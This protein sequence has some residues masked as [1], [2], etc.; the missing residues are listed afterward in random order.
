V[1]IGV[2]KSSASLI[3]A[4]APAALIG[5]W[6]LGVLLAEHPPAAASSWQLAAI[7]WLG[8]HDG[9]PS[10]PMALAYGCV[11]FGPLLVASLAASRFWAELFSRLRARPLDDGWALWAWLYALLLPATMPL[12]FAILGLSFGAVFG[13]HVFGGTGRYLVNPALLGV[14]F[15]TIAY[16]ALIVE[17][18]WLPGSELPSSWTLLISDGIEAA[19][20]AGQT[21]ERLFLGR[22]IGALGTG[23]A[24]ACLLGAGVLILRREAAPEIVAAGCAGLALAS[25]LGG[26]L[27]WHW[28]LVLGNFAFVLAFLAT[29]PTT[30]PT[31][32][33]GLWSFGA[34]FGALTI[35][36]RAGNPE[37]PEGTLFAL[38]LA[39]LCVPLLDRIATAGRARLERA[40]Q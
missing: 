15:I 30:Q 5:V 35:V 32:R 14:L 28:Q 40:G 33:A 27:P 29:D 20:A 21:W 8:A 9:S 18:Q 23:S 37:H 34:L 11:F 1:A 6:N 22:E 10:I 24:L 13:A 38:M 25:T 2:G 12:H 17:A 19:A 36:L 7:A 16:P 3:L 4:S 26:S 31:T 39:S